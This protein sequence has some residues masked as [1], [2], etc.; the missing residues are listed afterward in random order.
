M[1][2]FQKIIAGIC[3]MSIPFVSSCKKDPVTCNWAT[4]VQSE[5]N[6]L[7]TAAATYG[8]D[9]TTANCNAYKA[10]VQNYLNALEDHKGCVPS[11]QSAGLQQAIDD[12]RASLDALQC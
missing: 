4:E 2:T 1:N 7:S 5:L 11:E 8:N 6:A 12:E 9:P 3:I 10:A